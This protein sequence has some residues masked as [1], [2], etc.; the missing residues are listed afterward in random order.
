VRRCLRHG[1]PLA[2][3]S[4]ESALH[5]HTADALAGKPGF[6]DGSD[7]EKAVDC[8]GLTG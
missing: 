5:R 7:V 1:A 3:W 6:A 4:L 8:C 2:H